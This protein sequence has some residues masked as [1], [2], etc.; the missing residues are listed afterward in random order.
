MVVALMLRLVWH[1]VC[2]PLQ[3]RVLRLYFF[4][5]WFF[6]YTFVS[7]QSNRFHYD[8]SE[9][10]SLGFAHIL[11]HLCP[12]LTEAKVETSEGRWELQCSKNN[13]TLWRQGRPLMEDHGKRQLC[14]KVLLFHLSLP[15]GLKKHTHAHTHAHKCTH[16]YDLST[17]VVG[18]YVSLCGGVRTPLSGAS[19]HSCWVRLSPSS[20]IAAQL[21]TRL[22]SPLPPPSQ[23]RHTE[24]TPVCCDIQ[25]FLWVLG[26]EPE[27]SDFHSYA[28]TRGAISSAKSHILSLVN[29]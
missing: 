18:V 1:P 11:P 22:L 29:I 12:S 6:K 4:S 19:S 15:L 26:T 2:C 27:P 21:R 8:I 7:I 25:L 28:Y 13:L 9:Y 5:F 24:L 23:G 20:S 10:V 16:R 14:F 3:N 17:C